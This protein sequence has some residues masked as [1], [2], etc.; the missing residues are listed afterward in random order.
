[1]LDYLLQSP[2]A[3]ADNFKPR[4]K[5][6][7]AQLLRAYIEYS[8]ADHATGVTRIVSFSEKPTA[9]RTA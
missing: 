7:F 8:L 2:A 9:A 3:A 4:A 1:M 6:Q 5:V